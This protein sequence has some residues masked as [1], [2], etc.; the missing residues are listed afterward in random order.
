[1]GYRPFLMSASIKTGNAQNDPMVSGFPLKAGVIG[2][3]LVDS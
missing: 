3:E 2:R 1:M